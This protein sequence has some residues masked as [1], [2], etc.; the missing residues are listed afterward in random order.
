VCIESEEATLIMNHNRTLKY[1][2]SHSA[3]TLLKTKTQMIK[4]VVFL[5]N[6]SELLQDLIVNVEEP[7]L[8][9]K[10]IISSEEGLQIVRNTSL[11]H[12]S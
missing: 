9:R 4:F 3:H 5:Q 11:T 8:L 6:E 1:Q 12:C 2:L 10:D 7:K